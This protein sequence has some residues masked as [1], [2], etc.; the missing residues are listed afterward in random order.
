[1]ALSSGT[2]LGP[3][4]IVAPLGAGG[5]AEVYRARDARL[6]RTVAIKILP[7]QFSSDPVRKQRFERE[8]KTI[9]S[10]NHPHICVL[11]DVGS[12]DG[13][14]YL[15]MECVEGETLAKRLEK[16]AL[17]VEQV[18]KYG[19]QIADA[20]DKA[21]R[22]GVVHRD[23]KP[24]NIMLTPTGVKLL[25]FGLAKPVARPV[26]GAT[27]TAAATQTS[28]VTEQGTI[29]GTFQFMSPEQIEG[30]E[31]DG[32][33]DIFSLGAALYEMLTGQRAFQ[34]KSQLSVASA[35][36]ERE[37]EPL[38]TLRPMTPPALNFTVKKCLAKVPDERWQSASDL[39][40]ELKWIAESSSSSASVSAASSRAGFRGPLA[41][42]IAAFGLFAISA[43]LG[44]LHWRDVQS[45]SQAQVV[46]AFINAPEKTRFNFTGDASSPMTVS[47]DGTKVLFS[48]S[49]YLWIRFLNETAPKRLEGT[50][51]AVFPFWS[52]D[53]RFIGFSADGKLKTMDISG[54]PPVALCDAPGLRGASWGADGTILF[55]PGPRTR[56]FRI[57]AAGGT[58]VPVTKLDPTQHTTHR[59]PFFLPDG[60]HF[61]YLASNHANPRGTSTEIYV[62]S[63]DGQ[64]NRPLVHSF[65]RAEYASGYL[66]YLRDATLMAQRFEPDKLKLTGD[67]IPIAENVTEGVSTWG[68]VFSASQNGVLA[69]QAG[70]HTAQSELRWYD[71][72]GRNLGALGSGI[73]YGPRLSPDGTRLAADFG[74][75][76]RDVWIF[77][78]RR[79]VK[80]RFTFD[81]VD[82]APVWSPDGSRIAFSPL[83][84]DT[85]DIIA[86]KSNGEG[87][88][89]TLYAAQDTKIP[90]DWSPDGRFLLMDHNY[91]T[92]SE[93][94]VLPLAGNRKPYPFAQSQF[95]ER[96]GH[97]SPDGR[98][99]AYTS[100]E[101]GREE[102]YVA[103][104]P[105]PGGK[106]EVSGAGGKMPR[107]RR[108][109]R[110][111]YFFAEDDTLMVAEVEARSNK[112]EV[113]NVHPLFRA[114]LAPEALER[115]GSF[116]VAADG[117][118]FIINASSDEAQPPITLVL[119]WPAELKE[120]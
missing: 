99:V 77:D 75:P 32:R 27:L 82:A 116:D 25:D 6:E 90:T 42:K 13:I 5:M 18:L 115:S 24:G 60:K 23:L 118:R 107:W 109:G 91:S 7:A 101:S 44:Y 29:V 9:S 56:I 112:F 3:Y 71:R 61:L 53:G 66:L 37:P 58:A 67:A 33:S 59:W 21:H 102:V 26:T 48:A 86:K 36:L 113:R 52:P 57:A 30:K 88:N 62:A 85:S 47:P 4:E 10:L 96:S 38:N 34:G 93:V 100:R 65:G 108:D 39:A 104:F 78:L 79:G 22:S 84:G 111:L 50:Q 43:F 54:A 87:Q 106:W 41:W 69:Y 103:P 98:W 68:A 55:E 120:K 70:G 12:Q 83:F 35:I 51:D 45:A 80:T 20:L 72:Q 74:D 46:R 31:L 114:N 19:M 40:S 92:L 110:E 14:D 17:P 49:G 2:K 76:N 16:G 64:L 8:A 89:E 119:N 117:T 15:V 63:L 11:H 1:M 97:F 94:D 81:A 105:G 73:Y 28:P 95:P